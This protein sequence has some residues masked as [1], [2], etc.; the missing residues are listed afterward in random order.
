MTGYGSAEYRARSLS[1]GIHLHLLK[2]VPFERIVEV[3]QVGPPRSHAERN[4]DTVVVVDDNPAGLYA[5]KRG[6]TEH[7]FKVI[8]AQSGRE[9]L[10]LADQGTAMVLDVF[11]PD[12]DGFAVCRA[13]RSR[14]TTASLPILH[15]SS[16]CLT[17]SD[18]EEAKRAGGDAYLM[19]PAHT[20]T[21]SRMLDVLI[22]GR[23]KRLLASDSTRD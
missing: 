10:N 12:I 8:C 22:T 13:L 2:P 7:G 3:L 6:L 21:L 15:L 19:G 1:S 5:T 17:E 9:A 14:A 16:M 23:S 20:G 4:A 11:L 18:E